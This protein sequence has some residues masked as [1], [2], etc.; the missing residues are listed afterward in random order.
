MSLYIIEYVVLE[1]YVLDLACRLIKSSNF[2]LNKSFIP[3]IPYRLSI[4]EIC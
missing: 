2:D 3:G 4:L 1:K